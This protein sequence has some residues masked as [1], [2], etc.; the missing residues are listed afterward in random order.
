MR[1][2][3]A[4]NGNGH[5]STPLEARVTSVTGGNTSP[6]RVLTVVPICD[7]HD[8]AISTINIELVRHGIEVVYL[9]Y[10]RSVRDVVR[11]AVQEDVSA[12]GISSYNGGHVEFFSAVVAGLRAQGA[13]DVTVFG[14]GGGT[15]TRADERAMRRRGVGRIFFPGDSLEEIVAYVKTLDRP[16]KT[17]AKPYGL[18]PKRR[19]GPSADRELARALTSAEL[20]GRGSVR[21]VPAG[22][23]PSELR[24][25]AEANKN[26]RPTE[27]LV[28]GVT[29]PGGA[30]K[31]TLIDELIL[32]LLARNPAARVAV[33]S[34]DP[35]LVSAGAL[36]GDRAS[37]IYANDDRV[38]MR[39]LGTR[40]HAGGIA[41]ATARC[42]AALRAARPAF[43][44]VFVETVGT[45]QEAAPFAREP[46]VDRTL[47]VMSPDYGARLQLQKI[48]AFDVADVIAVNKGDLGPARTAVAE[49]GRRAAGTPLVSTI[50]KRHGDPGVDQ[51]L[52][53]L[54]RTPDSLPGL[55]A[56]AASGI[57]NAA[58]LP[59]NAHR[60]AE[61]AKPQAAEAVRKGAQK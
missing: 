33:L 55:A 53:L 17:G 56:S 52:D 50:A 61:A 6:V 28:I 49:I 22:G 27:P 36:L 32:R 34:H 44:V 1:N 48:A 29:G 26:A 18:R 7:G 47:L 30:G 35:S 59:K 15:I 38:F 54:M 14:G 16:K 4:H 19:P 57:G 40:G 2:G 8:S 25:A 10:H 60:R 11:A 58:I 39:S 20:G 3:R 23:R 51:L 43:D 31:T 9:G 37:M 24:S 21:A 42:L 13:T 5:P 41:A 45:G 12:V 46:L